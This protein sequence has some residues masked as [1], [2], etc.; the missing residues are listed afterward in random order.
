M[1]AKTI[2]ILDPRKRGLARMEI[3]ISNDATRLK[4]PP[5]RTVINFGK[6]EEYP[7]MVASAITDPTCVI[8]DPAGHGKRKMSKQ[9][10]VA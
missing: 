10:A 4:S 6:A 7:A 9:F 1:A 2:T 8:A 5:R 3:D